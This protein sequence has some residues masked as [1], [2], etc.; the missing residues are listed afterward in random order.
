MDSTAIEL[1]KRSVKREEGKKEVKPKRNRD[2]QRKVKSF[3]LKS[4]PFYSIR[5]KYMIINMQ[6]QF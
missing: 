2:V 1:R 5:R 4:Q 6:P 3:L